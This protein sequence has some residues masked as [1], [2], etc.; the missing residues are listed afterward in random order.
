M[1]V[2]G[3]DSM[4]KKRQNIIKSHVIIFLLLVL[5][6][7]FSLSCKK[8][9][10]ELNTTTSDNEQIDN[11]ASID[12][13]QNF[14]NI[15]FPQNQTIP[16]D[17]SAEE[18]ETTIIGNNTSNEEQNQTNQ[19]Q[20]QEDKEIEKPVQNFDIRI[21]KF[22]PTPKTLSIPLDSTVTWINNDNFDHAIVIKKEH[23]WH[24]ENTL[25]H[26]KQGCKY[27]WL[28][29]ETGIYVWYSSAYP[30]TQGKIIVS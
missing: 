20:E 19:S 27:T 4:K 6:S 8:N 24:P 1:F 11:K 15:A 2:F 13:A 14:S 7:F 30:P 16:P 29:N 17:K 28:F 23:A 18:N 5:I 26:C 9:I 10:E 12:D 22:V 21:Y 3:D 25:Q